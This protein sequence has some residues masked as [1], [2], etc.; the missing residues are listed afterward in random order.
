MHKHSPLIYPAIIGTVTVLLLAAPSLSVANQKHQSKK[1]VD[2]A[3]SFTEPPSPSSTA[4]PSQKKPGPAWRT[5]GGTVKQVK[6]TV[7]T[8]E[9]YEGNQV[10]FFVSRETKHLSGRKKIGDHIR[11]EIT[12]SGFANSIQ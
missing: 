3:T 7:Y 9:D 8:V 5:I 4:E 6:E 10:Q 12:H 1:T 11:A 2:S